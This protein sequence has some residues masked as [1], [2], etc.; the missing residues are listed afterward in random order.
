VST[1]QEVARTDGLYGRL[2]LTWLLMSHGLVVVS[3]MG[4]AGLDSAVDRTVMSTG[5]VL[6][7]VAS[8]WFWRQ[9]RRTWRRIAW[10]RLPDEPAD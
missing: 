4:L 8:G 3:V 6:G 2:W 5:I 7:V 9:W 1:F 10:Q